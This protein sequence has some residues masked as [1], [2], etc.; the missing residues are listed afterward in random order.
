MR[1]SGKAVNAV[2]NQRSRLICVQR[3]SWGKSSIYFISTKLLREQGYGPTII[4]S[5]LLALMRNQIESAAKYGVALGTVNS[6]QSPDQNTLNKQ[7]LLSGHLDALI[8]APEQL[9]KALTHEK[10]GL[11]RYRLRDY[12][13][14]CSIGDD[15]LVVLVLPVAHRKKVY[16]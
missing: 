14:I 16:K 11:W 4:I 7:Q 12:R 13:M 8:I 3:T 5:P 6:S 9:G 15:R 2:V 10:T 1:I